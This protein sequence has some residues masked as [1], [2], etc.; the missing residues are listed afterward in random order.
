ML[1]YP[2]GVLSDEALAT[3]LAVVLPHLDERQRRIVVGAE[4]RALGRGGVT[5]VARAAGMARST[6]HA[7]AKQIDEGV[8]VSERVRRPGGGRKRL[9]E[10]DPGLGAALDALVDPD[11]RGDPQSPLRWTSK[12]TRHLARTL[13]AAG[14]PVSHVVVGE[15]LKQLGYTLQGAAKTREGRQHPDRDAQFGYLNNQVK[16]HQRSGDPVISVD[17]KKK[18]LV[19]DYRNGGREWQPKGE[20]VQVNV[21]D[22]PDP[23]VGKAIPYGIYDVGADAGWVAVGTDHDTAAFAVHTLRRWWQTVGGQAYPE[24]T[25]LLICADGG[26]SN[27]YRNRLWKAELAS[28][29]ADTGLEIT[30]CHLPPGTSKWNRIEHRLFSHISMNWRGR[31]LT[32]HQVVVDLIGGTTT[33]TGLRVHAELDE[34]TYPTGIKVSDEQLAALPLTEHKFHGEWNYTIHP[35]A[36]PP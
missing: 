34:N 30:V 6:V 27:G 33:R 31:P 23:D 28:M 26:G 13:T 2:G 8:E 12:S 14:H 1:P 9:T 3:K 36:Q 16:D 17:T 22:F 21:Y 19:G 35:T 20:P 10:T 25:R 32:S 5:R 15:L 29:A 11:S 24:A 18:E 7:A 4:A